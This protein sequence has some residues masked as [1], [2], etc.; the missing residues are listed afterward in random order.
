VDYLNYPGGHIPSLLMKAAKAIA[1]PG[2]M[3]K[4]LSGDYQGPTIPARDVMEPAV[5]E[6]TGMAMPLAQPALGMVAQRYKGLTNPQ[7]FLHRSLG[8]DLEEI[9]FLRKLFRSRA[10]SE[11]PTT[12]ITPTSTPIFRGPE[13]PYGLVFS[14]RTPE[15]IAWAS[16]KDAFSQTYRGEKTAGPKIERAIERLGKARDE[17]SRFMLSNYG[18]GATPESL[19][20]RRRRQTQA[21]AALKDRRILPREWQPL[22]GSSKNLV[23]LSSQPLDD[24]FRRQRDLISKRPIEKHYDLI[25]EI[26]YRAGDP[27]ELVGV[28][29]PNQKKP[30]LPLIPDPIRDLIR[31]FDL[32]VW[33]FKPQTTKEETLAGLDA[34]LQSPEAQT[35]QQR[36]IEIRPTWGE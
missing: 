35:W 8:P 24:L 11:M 16:P 28:R 6:A 26:N 22:V 13:D 7:V 32:S 31:D 30:G 2:F 18:S 34:Y 14:V 4:W 36:G 29:I 20:A 25:N 3:E 5:S 10:K 33:R 9:G 15:N 21:L 23:D 1:L 17:L 27:L 12:A 19:L